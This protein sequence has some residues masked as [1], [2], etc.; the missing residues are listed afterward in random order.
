ML[1]KLLYFTTKHNNIPKAQ[2][3]QLL[4]IQLT[5]IFTINQQVPVIRLTNLGRSQFQQCNKPDTNCSAFKQKHLVIS[6]AIS[7]IIQRLVLEEVQAV[8]LMD[9]C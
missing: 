9:V 8:Q 5:R 1:A 4:L 3:N 6:S 7:D 2:K